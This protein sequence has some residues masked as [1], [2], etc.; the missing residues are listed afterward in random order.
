MHHQFHQHSLTYPTHDGRT[1]VAT[2]SL[3]SY[4]T[5]EACKPEVAST[6][7]PP[8][9]SHLHYL[10]SVL[11]P[12]TFTVASVPLSPPPPP[13]MSRTVTAPPLPPPPPMA[14]GTA[15]AAPRCHPTPRMLSRMEQ[16]HQCRRRRTTT[17]TSNINC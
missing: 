9:N 3:P 8:P 2:P 1:F 5:T 4:S 12:V 15:A 17:T 11:Q 6:Q 10:H 13:T 16:Q 14:S 7:S